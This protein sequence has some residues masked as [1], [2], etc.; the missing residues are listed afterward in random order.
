MSGHSKWHSIKHKKAKEDAK[1]GKIFTRLIK[2]LTVAARMGG[3]DP[4]GNPR[5]RQAIDAAK[6]ANMPKSNIENAIKKGTGELPGVTYEEAIYEGYGPAGVALLIETLTDN[7]N[8]TVAEI[9]H[10]LDKHGGN[11]GET[12]CVG[13]MFDR[14]G[15]ICVPK[16][17]VPEEEIF[18][19]A[20]EAGA[21]DVQDGTDMW[22]IYTEVGDIFEVKSALEAAGLDVE[23][24]ERTAVPQ[25]EVHVEGKEAERLLKLM[26]KLEDHDD[27][28]NVFSN[29]DIDDEVVA[30]FEAEE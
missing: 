1:R 19:K 26:D 23:S 21:T 20:L 14:V 27:V 8:R 25:S 12:G 5:L 16:E 28:Q 9:R 22:E 6:A 4:E 30:A 29:F 15:Y 13:W 24:A 18:E 3:G 10:I 2:E 7:R 17:G 11:L